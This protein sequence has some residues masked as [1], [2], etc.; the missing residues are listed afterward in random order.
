MQRC[1]AV[2]TAAILAALTNGRRVSSAPPARMIAAMIAQNSERYT[3]DARQ[4]GMLFV[5]KYERFGMKNATPAPNPHAKALAPERAL[6]QTTSIGARA[7]QA[8]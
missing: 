6:S 2:L 5:H 4:P 3:T 7:I 1:I 8:R